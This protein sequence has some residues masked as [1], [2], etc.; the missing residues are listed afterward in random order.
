[1]AS[2]DR[3]VQSSLFLSDIGSYFIRCSHRLETV[4]YCRMESENKDY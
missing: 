2:R 3:I 1:M 4:D